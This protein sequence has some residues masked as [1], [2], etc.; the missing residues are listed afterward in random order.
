MTPLQRRTF[1]KGLALTGAA[2][3]MPRALASTLG[4]LPGAVGASRRSRLDRSGSLVLVHTDLH[5]H[6]FVSGDAEGDPYKALHRI[7]D[8]GIDVACMTE[9]AVSGKDHGQY[10]CATWQDGGCRFI[11]GINQDD[12]ETMAK[13]ADDAYAPGRFVSFRG[14]EYSTPTVGHINVWFG[15]DFT[16]PLHEGALVT[17]REISEM[18]R[19]FPPTK[20][21]ADQFQKSPDTATIIPFYDWLSSP[22]GSTPLGGGS[23]AIASFNHPGYFGNFESFVYHAGASKRIFLMEAFNAIT[24]P[25]DEKHGH[26]ATD[27][28]WY[29][30]DRG[31]PQPFNACLNAGWRV[32]FTGVSDEHSGNY[33]QTGKGRGGLYV[34]EVT[35][36][37][38]HRAIMSRRSF[39]TR[40]AGLRLDATANHVPMGS[41]L[42][43]KS[44]RVTIRLDIDRGPDWVGKKLYVQVV[45]PGRD[46][47]VLLDVVPIRV[48][49]PDDPVVSFT[50]KASGAW[51]FLRIT[52]PARGCDPLG[53]APFEDATYGGAAAYTSPWFFDHD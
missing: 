33:G 42:T 36:A 18:W 15:T 27:Y 50:T 26:S 30:R 11:E 14:F 40:E 46:D 51:M 49:G 3:T 16:D 37:G 6:S 5:N 9:H 2:A 29:G 19:V 4:G 7:R 12:W 25:Q 32:G 17:P 8:A 45:G 44:K 21:V 22:P 28:F 48:P 39:G 20:P 38:V 31:L 41:T 23:D 47:P 10:D 1:L 13:I 43:P 52:D 24:Y 53:H 34:H 35:R